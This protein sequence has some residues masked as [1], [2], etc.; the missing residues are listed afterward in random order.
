MRRRQISH[1]FSTTALLKFEST[2]DK[3][4]DRLFDNLSQSNGEV[5]DM[6]DFI[7]CYAHD[8]IGELAFDRDLSTQIQPAAAKLPP[9][10]DHILLGSL[11][12]LMPS[13]MPYSMYIGNKLPIPGLQKLLAS[14]RQLSDQAAE[15]V[16]SVIETHKDGSLET[17]ISNV[18]EAKDPETGARLSTDEICAEAFA[19]LYAGLWKYLHER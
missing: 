2:F 4:L 3:H 15:Y 6:K 10:P 14:R 11:Y 13:L 12:G 7:S 9:I 17:L 8:V 1:S 19:F 16:K 5:F 18:I